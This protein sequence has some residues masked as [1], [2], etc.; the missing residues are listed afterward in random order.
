MTFNQAIDIVRNSK[1]NR[2]IWYGFE[3]KQGYV[4]AVAID[5]KYVPEDAAL[6]WYFV[7]EKNGSVS[8][9][10]YYG[11]LIFNGEYELGD[12]AKDKKVIDIKKEQLLE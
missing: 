9:F 5:N 4:F 11:R 7:D 1:P 8:E 6:T 2:L 3:Y 10:D 12:A